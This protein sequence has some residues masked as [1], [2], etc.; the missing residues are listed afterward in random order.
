MQA[1]VVMTINPKDKWVSPDGHIYSFSGYG[2]VQNC[3]KCD[4]FTQT[5]EYDRRDGAVVWFC[6][7]CADRL[8]L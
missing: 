8:Q 7:S 6:N 5:N 3:T 1:G 4:D 2:G